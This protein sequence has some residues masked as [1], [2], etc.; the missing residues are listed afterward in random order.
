VIP[1]V[2]AAMYVP[3]AAR[4][5]LPVLVE[6]VFYDAQRGARLLLQALEARRGG[7][8]GEEGGDAA[9]DAGAHVREGQRGFVDEGRGR[10][11]N[12]AG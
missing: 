11:F 12:V 8:L 10:H 5:R 1:E 9:M 6:C 2:L 3:G 4:A 7:L